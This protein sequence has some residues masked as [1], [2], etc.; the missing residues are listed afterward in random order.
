[1]MTGYVRPRNPGQTYQMSKEPDNDHLRVDLKFDSGVGV[2]SDYSL[3]NNVANVAFSEGATLPI[4]LKGTEDD[5]ITTGDIVSV[6]DGKSHHYRI[7]I[8]P[9]MSVKKMVI[10]GKPGIS[11]IY[12][13]F[14]LIVKNELNPATRK[15]QQPSR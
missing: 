13:H 5:G 6:L 8:N 2:L 4:L 1:M 7:P 12:R 3:Q 15:G 11:I 10:D 9:A 14:P